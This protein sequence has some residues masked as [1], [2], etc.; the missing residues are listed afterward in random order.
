MLKKYSIKVSSHFTAAVKNSAYCEPTTKL[1]QCTFKFNCWIIDTNIGCISLYWRYFVWPA[2]LNFSAILSP[3]SSWSKAGFCFDMMYI[4]WCTFFYRLPQCKTKV[5][6]TVAM[7]PTFLSRSC[8]STIREN[9][10]INSAGKVCLTKKKNINRENDYLLAIRVNW[11]NNLSCIQWCNGNLSDNP[12]RP[13]DSVNNN[14]NKII[15][16]RFI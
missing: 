3:L 8:R 9:E 11:T 4:W 5:F 6:S 13:E 1:A 16:Q 2:A 15:K 14:N 10:A 12:P 7:N